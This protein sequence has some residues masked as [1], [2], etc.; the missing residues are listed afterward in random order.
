[1]PI[2]AQVDIISQK[3]P[4]VNLSNLPETQENAS[5]QEPRVDWCL[6]FASDSLRWRCEFSRPITER[7]KPKPKP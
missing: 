2:V 5:D 4:E 3:E 6:I 1:M 7:G